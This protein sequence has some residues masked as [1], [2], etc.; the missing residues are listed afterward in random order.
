MGIQGNETADLE[1]K[2]AVVNRGIG[3][4]KVPYTD[5]KPIIRSYIRS[6]WQEV[7]S[8]T[9][10]NNNR[11]YREIRPSVDI[12]SSSCH[13]NRAFETRLTRLRIGHTRLTHSHKLESGDP[14]M[15]GPC[16]TYLTVKHILVDCCEYCRVRQK[17][18]LNGK[19]ITEIL[20]NDI[21][22][23]NV[24]NFLKEINLFDQI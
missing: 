17:Y 3:Y 11:K 14:P 24:M 2:A 20:N 19:L 8:S 9:S 4:Q 23:D 16:Q 6:K 18:H 7:W 10:L 1:A 12:W 22:I 13:T 15:C 5:M 21:D